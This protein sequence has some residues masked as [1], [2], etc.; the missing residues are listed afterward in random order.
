MTTALPTLRVRQA[1]EADTPAVSAV[2]VEA[3]HWIASSGAPMWKAGELS[4]DRIA[5]DVRA[6]LFF[7]ADRDGEVQGT[8]KFELTD[9]RFWPDRPDGESAFVHRLAVRRAAAGTGVSFVLL[10]WAR[11]QTA[12]LGRP[13]LRLDCEA[14][15][16]KL[17]Q[18]YERFGFE[19]HTD[20]WYGPYRVAR[21][22]L[23]VNPRD[24]QVVSSDPPRGDAAT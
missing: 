13:F 14:S 4:A 12:A 10:E 21:Y 6:G 1:T 5:D 9:P 11:Q 8:L 24:A 2:L 17:R 7:V 19:Y 18:L 20:W 3:A 23:A 16:A 22:Q 15:R